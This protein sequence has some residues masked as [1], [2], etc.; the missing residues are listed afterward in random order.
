MEFGLRKVVLID[1]YVAGQA[2]GLDV[3]GHTNISGENGRGKTS[4][5]KLIP[6][7][8]G[9]SPRELA[10]ASGNGNVSFNEYYLPR[11]GSYLV[12]E[13]VSFGQPK[14][15]VFCNRENESRH[16][17][18][19]ID[20][21]YR[22]DLFMD[23]EHGE[24][25]PAASL[26]SRVN[27]EGLDYLNVNTTADYRKVLLDGTV[28]KAYHFSMCERNARMSK[29][30]PLFTGMFKRDAQFADL[31][32]V[33]QEYAMDKLD[34]ES[35]EKLQNFSI[36]R[37]HLTDTLSHYDAHQALEKVREDSDELLT[38]LDEH[39]AVRTKLSA[40]VVAAKSLC[41]TLE[42]RARGFRSKA[43]ELE[44]SIETEGFDY[45]R[46]SQNLREQHARL[47][48]KRGPI[49]GEIDDIERKKKA[50]DKN[51]LPHWERQL[52]LL[53]NKE[54]RLDSLRA[55]RQTLTE[56]TDQ[57]RQPIEREIEKLRR[58]TDDF[59]R[60]RSER[61]KELSNQ[62]RRDRN[63][64]ADRF[65]KELQ[66]T[67]NRR[68]TEREDLARKAS[69]LN[70]CIARL[71]GR[72]ENPQPTPE[73]QK[74]FELAEAEALSSQQD[75]EHQLNEKTDAD[76]A[77]SKA[78]T[79]YDTANAHFMK[80]REQCEEL[81]PEREK[82]QSLIDG[83]QSTLIHFLNTHKPGWVDTL[84]RVLQPEILRKR[85]LSPAIDDHHSDAMSLFG[86][87]IDYS[88]LPEQDL[89]P[90]SL[91]AQFAEICERIEEAEREEENAEKSLRHANDKRVKAKQHAEAT[92]RLF[93]QAKLKRDEDSRT[94]KTVRNE[95][96]LSI[97][98][99]SKAIEAELTD[100]RRQ[101]E[102]LQTEIRKLAD[103]HEHE[104]NDLK[105]RHERKLAD[106][107]SELELA[108][109]AIDAEIEEADRER[110]ANIERLETQLK[111]A[112]AGRGIDPTV[113]E[114]L[115]QQVESLAKEVKSIRDHAIDVE[116]F[117]D[118]LAN[119]YSKL[120]GLQEQCSA[121][122]SEMSSIEQ[123]RKRLTSNWDNRRESLQGE[124]KKLNNQ[125]DQAE[126]AKDSL[127]LRVIETA[128]DRLLMVREDDP[129]LR[130]Y[131]EKNASQ[132]EREYQKLG[133][134]EI[135]IERDIKKATSAFVKIF[136]QYPGTPS[137]QYWQESEANWDGADERDI[138]RA[139]A[140]VDYFYTGKHDMVRETLVTGFSNLDQIDIYRRAME[141][142]D[143]RIRRF[144]RELADNIE[145]NLHFKA[146]EAIE[147]T[148]SF[149]LDELD[150]WRDIKTLADGVRA[151]RD[152][153]DMNSLPDS[154]LV[155]TLRNYLE[156]FEESRANVPV[157]D[158]W[159]LIRFR[160]SIIENG[161][162]KTV[163]TTKDLTGAEGVSSNGLSY[164]ILIVLFLGFVD[165]QRKRQPVHLT[166]ALDELRAF[167]NH[168]KRALLALLADHD[169]SL[170][171]ACPDMED[172]ELSLFHHVY[173]LEPHKG[174]LRFV[175]WTRPPLRSADD[176]NP[177]KLATME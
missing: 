127:Q 170:V 48:D 111:E 38:M 141:N 53:G 66:D 162:R 124:I 116:G 19:F 150:Y 35:R 163:S 154:D 110:D 16:R 5:L 88:Q 18:V 34:E 95:R 100:L 26:L 67:E 31:S 120:N 176:S 1:S 142:F 135:Q 175:L 104:T 109:S 72:K 96:R 123:R 159:R 59:V 23:I 173:K 168:N 126:A 152:E 13:Y 125:K 4:F 22:E 37:D 8:Y 114:S 148:V 105:E 86:V 65:N 71:E 144:N 134:R 153:A 45:E 172:R 106:F 158:L 7:F 27:A 107:D 174:G 70:T 151:W 11:K 10:R 118:F 145:Q 93:K 58:N 165:I 12:Y 52:E 21:P 137:T 138:A 57:I 83:D 36:H 41:A 9:A 169:I 28:R 61:Q 102:A 73:L 84:G 46:E 122:E 121:L 3:S 149:E 29:L 155:T 156:T 143:L 50:Y 81:E 90:D 25:L 20:S 167:D 119:E 76:A 15:V 147:P 79:A 63:A 55:Q 117:K 78:Q 64:L 44:Q 6:A 99:A 133:Q 43:H 77:A 108:L 140:V 139:R 75:Y 94:L 103:R 98:E 24:I 89:T 74:Q 62:G 113:V 132:I 112:L 51:D 42:I 101:G 14:M 69:D 2:S 80:A 30:T 160:F 115:H 47:A 68:A 32:R 49:L 92:E 164:L 97:L 60:A 177:F 91:K 128:Q 130:L 40:V 85:N 17:H 56:E 161:Q 146:L 129:D 87:S 39:G 82:T 136:E 171:T 166:W 157:Q 33:I 131:K 54:Q